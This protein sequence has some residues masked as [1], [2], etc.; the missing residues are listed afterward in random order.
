MWPESPLIE[1]RL[2]RGAGFITLHAGQCGRE[3]KRLYVCLVTK[4]SGVE[5]FPKG[6]R[7]HSAAE[8]V[9][10][11]AARHW[12]NEAGLS[13]GR[14]QLLRYFHV[15]D[16]SYGCRYLIADC[17][18]PA[19]GLQQPDSES[20]SWVPPATYAGYRDPI[21]KA[22]WVL[23]ADVL[24]RKT[25]LAGVRVRML[26]KALQCRQAAGINDPELDGHRGGV[27]QGRGEEQLSLS[28][29]R[30]G[31]A[32]GEQVVLGGGAPCGQT[33][34]DAGRRGGRR[35][36]P[37]AAARAPVDAGG[38]D[39]E[40][41]RAA[42]RTWLEAELA[43]RE[44]QS[45][46]TSPVPCRRG[47]EICA[48]FAVR[49]RCK[50][51]SWCVRRHFSSLVPSRG[52]VRAMRRGALSWSGL[53]CSSSKRII[54]TETVIHGGNG[55]PQSR[56]IFRRDRGS[57]AADR[58]DVVDVDA[59]TT[60]EGEE[61]ACPNLMAETACPGSDG[62]GS[63]P[64]ATTDQESSP[65]VDMEAQRQS[66]GPPTRPS[67]ARARAAIAKWA[68]RGS[69]VLAAAALPAAAEGAPTTFTCT[70]GDSAAAN[71]GLPE[72][73]SPATAIA[74]GA[75][76]VTAFIIGRWSASR[77]TEPP[78]TE[79]D[80]WIVV[81]EAAAAPLKSPYDKEK[82]S[83]QWRCYETREVASQAPC[84][85]T[86]VRGHARGRFLPLPESAHG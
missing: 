23:V 34:S 64:E 60:E 17:K 10:G 71:G 67:F 40:P 44:E 6:P 29:T 27:D 84:T 55:S 7:R 65:D 38:A 14:L 24:Q 57:T 4:Q 58:Q 50:H 19:I 8:T 80:P 11:A 72:W 13:M 26:I 78:V 76:V 79:R 16:P 22:R 20:K 73:L 37:A 30:D 59:T 70:A 9:F 69:I 18:E 75:V 3:G 43:E 63:S 51:G 47:T 54:P 5:S 39:A 49:G 32:E 66:A 31:R 74:A 81:A 52:D 25:R 85:Y 1:G 12:M 86:F 2:P 53:V 46:E 48:S 42:L 35:S 28:P 41:E 33:R 68:K 56:E 77:L 21:V 45:S 15:D 83:T 82:P 62:E 61:H 36:S